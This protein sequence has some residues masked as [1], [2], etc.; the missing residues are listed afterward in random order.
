[1]AQVE[2]Q[3]TDVTVYN[4]RARVVRSG[5]LQV[6]AGL[7]RVEAAGLPLALMPAT[8]RAAAHGTARARLASVQANRVF[9]VETPVEKVQALEKQI[10]ELEDEIAALDARSERLAQSRSALDGLLSQTKTYARAISKGRMS[11]EEQRNLF[12]HLGRQAADIDQESQQTTIERRELEKRL[13]ALRREL[14]GWQGTPRREQYTAVIELEV[15]QAGEL[16]FEISYLVGNA[17]WQPLYDVRLLEENGQPILEMGYLA[18]I[19]QR[20][21]E[22]WDGVSLTLSTARPALAAVL[23]ELSPWFIQPVPPVAPIIRE[24]AAAPAARM[25][26]FELAEAPRRV[27]PVPDAQAEVGES[28]TA[29]TYNVA[30][31]PSIPADGAP[32]KVNVARYRLE[33]E[34]DYISAPR[35]VAAVY[36]RAVVKNQ[37]PYTLLPGEANLFDAAEFIGATRLELT[38][39][40]GEIELFMGVED[41]IRVERELQRRDIDRRLIG[42]RR[43]LQVGYEITI[44]N[45]LSRAVQFSLRDQIPVARH[46]EIKVKLDK[47]QPQP[48]E[49]S[50]LNLL[51]WR[52]PLPP[53]EKRRV[54]YEFSVEY[55]REMEVNGLP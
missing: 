55:P 4:N 14:D 26:Q 8:L 51:E 11:P 3:I 1:M 7:Q 19:T 41:R 20:T 10:R 34:L 23:P 5:K 6:E 30:G 49:H 38:A 52:L 13:D 53:G 47:A 22:A 16:S 27:A 28:G 33:P 36:R 12:E 32:H 2:T 40:G 44:E 37:S 15:E 21:G 50:E 45:L 48:D 54:N 35:R 39:P 43:R 9:F 18:Q 42:G 31:A 46:E 24:A 29:V 25:A 17:G